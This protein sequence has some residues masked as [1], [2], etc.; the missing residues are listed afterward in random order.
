M[1]SKVFCI[2]F[3]KTGTTSL[4]VALKTLGYR[5]TGPNGVYDSNIE[6]NVLPLAFALVEEYDAFQDNPWPVIYK[7]LDLKFPGSR[8]ILMLR[9]PESWIRSQVRHFGRENT[10]MRKWIYG[11]GCPEGNEDIYVRRFEDHNEE[12]RSYFENRPRDLLILDLSKGDGWEKLCPFLDADSPGGAFPHANKS[13]T[14]ER[15]NA[16]TVLS[17]GRMKNVVYRI[18][19]RFTT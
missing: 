17:V 2:G 7:D 4:A 19:R 9:S 13:S 10:P 15:A 1:K 3:H 12:V 5:V 18:K 14:R 6:R 16:S 8:F 11:V